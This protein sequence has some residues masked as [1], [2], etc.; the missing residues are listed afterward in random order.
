[1]DTPYR[2]VDAGAVTARLDELIKKPIY[3]L[4]KE[5]LKKYEDEYYGGRCRGSH[6]MI[7][8]AQK[9]IPGGVQHNLTF[10]YPFPLVFTK[11]LGNKLYDMDGNEYLDFLQAVGPT[12]LGSNPPRSA[13][14]GHRAAGDLRPL[15]RS[16]PRVRV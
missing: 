3:T 2:Y 16:F 9:A 4:N 1:M 6:A 15:H 8:K 5:V 13:Q 14:Q 10:N 7:D 12:I 11:A